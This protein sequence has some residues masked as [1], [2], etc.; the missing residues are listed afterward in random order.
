MVLIINIIKQKLYI[1]KLRKKVNMICKFAN[2]EP[3]YQNVPN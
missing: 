3:K 2:D 1:E